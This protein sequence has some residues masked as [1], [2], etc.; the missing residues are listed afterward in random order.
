ML[1]GGRSHHQVMMIFSGITFISLFPLMVTDLVMAYQYSDNFCAI[2]FI[3]QGLNLLVWIRTDGF[4][5]IA[6]LSMTCFFRLAAR[7]IKD[8]HLLVVC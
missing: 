5:K 7:E 8:H 6:I 1:E 2:Q 3:F 4:I